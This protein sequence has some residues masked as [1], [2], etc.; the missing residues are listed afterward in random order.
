[1]TCA[2][3]PKSSASGAASVLIRDLQYR[4]TADGRDYVIE[5]CAPDHRPAPMP[6]GLFD[7]HI[8]A[9]VPEGFDDE[10]AEPESRDHRNDNEH[11]NGVT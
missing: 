5:V 7:A 6:A 9:D 3:P 1:M 2:T 10:D 11:K 4:L 8:L